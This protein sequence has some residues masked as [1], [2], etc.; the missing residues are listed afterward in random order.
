MHYFGKRAARKKKKKTQVARLCNMWLPSGTMWC[1]PLSFEKARS[2]INVSH[3]VQQVPMAD[4]DRFPH[5]MNPAGMLQWN[6]NDTILGDT[7]F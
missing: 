7:N 1:G 3:I 2:D 4:L 5:G 6:L